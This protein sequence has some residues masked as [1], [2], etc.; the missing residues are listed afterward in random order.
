MWRHTMKK[1]LSTLFL[2]SLV[3][4]AMFARPMDKMPAK[5]DVNVAR[6]LEAPAFLRAEQQ[7]PAIFA[8]QAPAFANTTNRFDTL[9]IFR[10]SN[11]YFSGWT[12]NLRVMTYEPQTN[13]VLMVAPDWTWNAGFTAIDTS[14]VNVLAYRDGGKTRGTALLNI[15]QRLSTDADGGGMIAFCGFDVVND[16]AGNTEPENLNMF[17]TGMVY[18]NNGELKNAGGGFT[19]YDPKNADEAGNP[20]KTHKYYAGPL[21]SYK[22]ADLSPLG[23]ISTVDGSTA[24]LGG[25]ALFAETGTGNPHGRY[26]FLCADNSGDHDVWL[27]QVSPEFGVDKFKA[28]TENSMYNTPVYIDRDAAGTAYALVNNI[29]VDNEN[30]RYPAVAKSTDD[31]ATW[32][33]F[34]K[35]PWGVFDNFIL[36]I[37]DQMY[38]AE[39][40]T[41]GFVPF[42]SSDFVVTGTDEFS[43]LTSFYCQ[44]PQSYEYYG[45]GIVEIYKKAGQWGMRQV[46][47]MRYYNSDPAAMRYVYSGNFQLTVEDINSVEDQ[48]VYSS[49]YTRGYEI[50]L[51]KTADGQYLVAK[52]VEP[53]YTHDETYNCKTDELTA[54]DL[55]ADSLKVN[56]QASDDSWNTDYI[57]NYVPNDIFVKY[58]GVNDETW[59]EPINV[60][61][62]LNFHYSTHM[63]DLLPNFTATEKLIPLTSTFSWDYS[64]Y[65]SLP[66]AYTSI[67]LAMRPAQYMNYKTIMY[68]CFNLEAERNAVEENETFSVGVYPNPATGEFTVKPATEGMNKV[69]VYTM[70]GDK[71][72]EMNGVQNSF[73]AST[74]GM[75]SG[76]YVIKVTNNGNTTSSLL[77][78]TK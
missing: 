62:D 13:S 34:D 20:F 5:I 19:F 35:M 67:P 38:T 4:A 49:S 58:R 52:W 17:A 77:T 72:M 51:A 32:S 44:D 21:A 57:T 54:I 24:Y 50:E 69:E 74:S 27:N 7:T 60:T 39:E 9:N 78:V 71:V 23:F 6:Q 28:G 46:E 37:T 48:L 2:A 26:G 64:K 47:S 59:S 14:E 30:R 3:P 31:G 66:A 56:Y 12:Y 55:G 63:P 45:F 36:G 40:V 33:E 53:R 61:N 73:T 16:I 75:T 43:F 10:W 15:G 18:N 70:V 41:S 1:L 22:W 76:V 42:T 11:F 68:G 25:D 29:Y 8:K 65:T